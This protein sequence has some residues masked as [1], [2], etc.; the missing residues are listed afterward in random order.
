MP[1]DFI[2]DVHT[3]LVLYKR[4]AG[5]ESTADLHDLQVEMI[6]RFGILP[7]AAKNLFKI[8][9]LKLLAVPMRIR[10][11]E[12]G[13]EQARVLFDSEPNI[14]T[15]IL[16]E[17]IQSKPQQY[18]FEGGNKLRIYGDFPTGEARFMAASELLGLLSP[19]SPAS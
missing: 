1:D 3:R 4:V 16:I 18:R 14:N 8:A 7:D 5:M 6:D 11:I 15:D 9:E 2:R 19:S 17:L 10:K 12:V 13:M